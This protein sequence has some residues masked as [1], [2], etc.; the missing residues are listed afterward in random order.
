[1]VHTSKGI[2]YGSKQEWKSPLSTDIKINTKTK[3]NIK[4]NCSVKK[5][6]CKTIYIACLHLCK[7]GENISVS[8]SIYVL[9]LCVKTNTRRMHK[10]LVIDLTRSVTRKQDIQWILLILFS[11]LSHGEKL[12]RQLRKK[13]VKRQLN[14]AISL[15]ANLLSGS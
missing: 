15:C 11:F 4:I 8:I 1:M 6:K 7:K 12:R 9:R 14:G 10:K 3:E 13:G 2:P 5:A